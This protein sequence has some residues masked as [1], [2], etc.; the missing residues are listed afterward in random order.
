MIRVSALL[1]WMKDWIDRAKH[2]GQL[3]A[4]ISTTTAA[5]YVDPQI[6]SGIMMQAEGVEKA[7]I[8]EFL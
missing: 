3:S 6:A 5:L 4:R 7:E 1:A 2:N 8:S